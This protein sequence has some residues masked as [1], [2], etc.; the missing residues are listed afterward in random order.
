M[1][2]A[3]LMFLIYFIVGLGATNAQVTRV[4][5]S[6]PGYMMKIPSSSIYRTPY[7]FRTGFCADTYGFRDTLF[8]KAVFLETDITD[9]FKIGMTTIQGVSSDA[10]VEFGLHFQKRLFVY[11]DISFSAGINDLVLKQGNKNVDLDTKTLSIF[12]VISNEKQIG[13][14]KL[15]TYMGFGTGGLATGFADTTAGVF[16]GMLFHT[17]MR[18][19][20]GGVDIVGEF[21]GGALNFGVKVPLSHD[22][23]LMLGINN[24]TKLYNF[25]EKDL[26]ISDLSS[27]PSLSLGFDFR[28]PRLK[29][30]DAKKRVLEGMVDRKSR[31]ILD[32]EEEFARKL[33][34]TL[35]AADYQIAKLRDSLEI[36]ETEI[37][38]LT[39]QVAQLR[40]KTSI[41]EDSVRTVKLAK[42]AMDHNINLALKHL[43]K[44]L[45]YFYVNDYRSA[46]QEVE[47]AIELNS[48]LAL[49]YAR[50]GSIYYKLGDIDRATI[51][52]N[53]ALKIDPEYDDVR[54]ILRAMN[55][56]RLH[57]AGKKKH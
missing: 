27:N 55:E 54:N 28:I 21:D 46:L 34:S 22:Y 14:N 48:N 42:H 13:E 1:R 40:Q 45:R 53:L 26:D 38:Y 19:E 50:R 8:S 49:A 17:N 10:P 31:M 32:L 35:Q 25:G 7:V 16:A 20:L 37:K 6:K 12:G 11:G 9:A 51:N 47:A 24:I 43:S 33:D 39:S 18:E 30:R 4:A 41:L 23:N 5:F 3:L 56:N 44:S 36:Y 2:K 15:F 29:P 57:S 52:W